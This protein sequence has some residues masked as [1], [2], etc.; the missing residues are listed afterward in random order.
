MRRNKYNAIKTELDG[1]IFDS[2]REATRY[3]ELSILSRTGDIQDLQIHTPYKLVVNGVHICTY[4]ADF[5]YLENGK[6]IVEDVKGMKTAVYRLKKK[7]MKA[8]FDID[9]LESS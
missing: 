4:E 7:L 8:L 2:R 6:R 5:V 9:I 3:G 1:H